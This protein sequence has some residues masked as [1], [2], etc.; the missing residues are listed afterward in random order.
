MN[1]KPHTLWI[2]RTGVLLALTLAAQF[3]GKLVP[4][5]AALVGPLSLTQLVTGSLVNMLLVLATGLVGTGSGVIIG[6]LSALLA[7][8]LGIGPPFPQISPVIALGSAL[9]VLV[10]SAAFYAEKRLNQG[11]AAWPVLIMGVLLGAAIKCAFLWFAVPRVLAF[12]PELK[13]PQLAAL[14]LMFSWPQFVT[15]ILGGA[16][17]LMMLSPLRRALR[18]N[19]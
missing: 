12:I 3:L 4:G 10:A 19:G 18:Q 13:A 8:L 1:S 5:G 15:A 11:R 6:V 9:L 2:T 14:S 16:L 7:T 17:A